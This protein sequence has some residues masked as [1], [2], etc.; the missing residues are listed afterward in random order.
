MEGPR[1]PTHTHTVQIITPFLLFSKLAYHSIAHAMCGE[2]PVEVLEPRP[3]SGMHLQWHKTKMQHPKTFGQGTYAGACTAIPCDRRRRARQ[4]QK[5]TSSSGFSSTLP[6]SA[7]QCAD[8]ALFHLL[9]T[10]LACNQPCSDTFHWFG[11]S[12]GVQ[13]DGLHILGH[14]ANLL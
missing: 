6:S 5:Q 12:S 8:L 10:A 9:S 2:S 3:A 13:P 7:Q 14:S 1:A 4:S 11:V